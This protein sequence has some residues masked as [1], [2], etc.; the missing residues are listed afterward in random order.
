MHHDRV[1]VMNKEGG[2]GG[3]RKGNTRDEGKKSGRI[4]PKNSRK[5]RKKRRGE[6]WQSYSISFS[7][8]SS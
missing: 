1:C 5:T 2:K 6:S 7:P 8:S 3:E 4:Q